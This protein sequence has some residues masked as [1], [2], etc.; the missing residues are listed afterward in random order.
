MGNREEL[1]IKRNKQKKGKIPRPIADLFMDHVS[2]EPNSG[3]WLWTANVNECGYG[4]FMLS[5]KRHLA[6]RVAYSLF[7]KEIPKGMCVCHKCDTP[8]CV[9]PHHLFIGT[10]KD[11]MNDMVRKKRSNKPKHEAHNKAKLTW[12][13]VREI[14]RLGEH[15]YGI[16]IA[17]LFGVTFTTI[18][19]ILNNKTWKE[20]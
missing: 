13:Q 18:S 20:V 10:V 17:P 4:N 2:P 1:S 9:N 7:I 14:R 16:N 11:N 19:S 6:H 8:A 12:D 5:G 3:C 15:M